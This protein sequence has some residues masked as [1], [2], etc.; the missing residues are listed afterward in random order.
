MTKNIFRISI[1]LR[2]DDFDFTELQSKFQNYKT[3]CNK[4][5]ES[6]MQ[7]KP[8]SH[9]KAK[10]NA[11]IISDIYVVNKI[12]YDFENNS[13][14]LISLIDKLNS[15]IRKNVKNVSREIHISGQI[16]DQ[17]FGIGFSAH[18]INTISKY[19]YSIVFSGIAFSN[20]D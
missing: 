18:F 13:E 3:I 17:Q 7:G 8:K 4:K 19:N 10:S 14:K 1:V 16:N 15:I 5:G 12:D 20:E 9:F 2:S 11:F 6:V